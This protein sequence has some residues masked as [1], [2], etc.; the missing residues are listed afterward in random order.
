M[1]EAELI[2]LSSRTVFHSKIIEKQIK[3]NSPKDKNIS[4]CDGFDGWGPFLCK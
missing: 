4:V 2:E 1:R 3:I